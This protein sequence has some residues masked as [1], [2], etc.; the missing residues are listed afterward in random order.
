MRDARERRKDSWRKMLAHM[1]QEA[2]K[3][4]RKEK[5]KA[6]KE[7]KGN[8][9]PQAKAPARRNSG[10][11]ASKLCGHEPLSEFT[12]LPEKIQHEACLLFVE[13]AT[14]EDVAEYINELQ[15]LPTSEADHGQTA[16]GITLTAVQRYFRGNLELQTRRIKRLQ[17][18]GQALK[19][20]LVGDPSSAEAELADAI[21]FTGLMGMDRA[22]T[23]LHLREAKQAFLSRQSLRLKRDSFKLKALDSEAA[24]KNVEARTATE[25]KKQEQFNQ[26]I[27]ELEKTIA[28]ETGSHQLGPETLEKIREIYGLVSEEPAIENRER[29]ICKSE[30]G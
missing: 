6:E 10:A 18:R 11:T 1:N 13:G 28:K 8:G 27:R 12:M 29:G 21:F 7:R 15:G 26:K 30:Q 3:A 4:R 2:D 23:H 20:A 19:Q 9:N 16:P 24:R 22:R 25:L 5:R 14:F 17:E